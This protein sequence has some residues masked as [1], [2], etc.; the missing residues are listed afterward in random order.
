M[1]YNMRM[2]KDKR[3]DTIIEKLEAFHKNPVCELQFNSTF[4]LLVAVIL[5]A[6][7]T[8]KRVNVVTQELF[9]VANTPEAMANMDIAELE[10]I[11]F[12]VGF[13]H[14]KASH[15]MSASRDILTRF[16]GEVP[17]NI[18]DLMSLSG[19]G[20][21]TANVVYAVGFGGQAIAVD[22]HVFRVSHRLGLSNGKTPLDVERDLMKIIPRDKWSSTHHLLIHQG[23]YICKS[24]VPLCDMCPV[25]E[26]CVSCKTTK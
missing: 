24:R 22:T 16:G 21:K 4:E 17:D 11:I 20:R 7:C 10:K 18:D 2:S 15:I 13:Y 8:D 6:Q 26:E 23:R 19:V 14:N 5:S 12:P 3:V 25:K 1:W 9:K